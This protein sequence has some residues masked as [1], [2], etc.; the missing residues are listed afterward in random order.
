MAPISNEN[1]TGAENVPKSKACVLLAPI[2]IFLFAT[3]VDICILLPAWRVSV[4]PPVVASIDKSPTT[5]TVPKFS[6]KSP[7]RTATYAESTIVAT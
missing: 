6:A 3:S 4:S 1:V 5:A 2:V 7:T